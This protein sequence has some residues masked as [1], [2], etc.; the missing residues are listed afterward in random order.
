[1]NILFFSTDALKEYVKLAKIS[2]LSPL[3]KVTAVNNHQNS[4]LPAQQEMLYLKTEMEKS[5]YEAVSL[6]KCGP[7]FDL[8]V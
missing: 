3:M 5:V 4:K 6:L 2:L 8:L 1:M 7:C